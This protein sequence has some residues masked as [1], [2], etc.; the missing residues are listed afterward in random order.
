MP[1]RIVPVPVEL[2]SVSDADLIVDWQVGDDNRFTSTSARVSASA[3]KV[4]FITN[5]KQA[6]GIATYAEKA[7]PH[8]AKRIGDFKLFV[9]RNDSPTSPM[10]EFGGE[11]IANEKVV[12]CWKRGESLL[13]LARQVQAYNPDI[14]VI[15]HEYGIF[16]ARQFLSLSCQ[17]QKYRVIT[18]AHSV[19]HHPDKV[20]CE[21][22]MSEIVVHLDGAK[23]ILK[24]EKKVSG[25]VSI[26]PHGCDTLS[27]LPRLWNFYRS[28]HTFMSAGFSYA[29]KGVDNSI[30]AVAILREKYPDVF[31]TG[32]LSESM[33]SR[34]EH[35][36]LYNELMELVE[37]LGVQDN[38][39]LI[40]GFQ[41]DEVVSAFL[42]TNKV[43]VFPYKSNGENE[44]HGASGAVRVAMA[45]GIPVITSN[46]PH[47]SD[48]PSVKIE[49][50]EEMAIELEKFFLSQDNVSW[51]LERQNRYLAENSWD[52]I[53]DRYVDVF[54]SG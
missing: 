48:V 42:R 9:E 27:K 39:S 1:Q 2:E 18:I 38:V 34:A 20:I 46:V 22:A 16:P 13:P 52:L 12:E 36:S 21:A 47:F 50:P 3:L 45:Q 6:C 53:A 54:V 26:I 29:Y 23:R 5:W 4:A 43:A 24:D 35:S 31:F 17:L 49:S 33:H 28:E 11:T 8:I 10:N 37:E 51:Q 7:Y 44:V 14:V 19:F 15:N 30:R 40:R 25:K 32:L 41:T